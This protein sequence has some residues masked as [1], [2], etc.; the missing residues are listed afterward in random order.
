MKLKSIAFG[1]AVFAAT[2]LAHAGTFGVSLNQ[3]APGFW[4]AGYDSDFIVGPLLGGAPFV[5]GTDTVVFQDLLNP[6]AAGLYEVELTFHELA[7][8]SA[9]FGN[10]IT[11][12]SADVN[13]VPVTFFTKRTFTF[14]GT[15]AHPFVLTVNG[16]T[17]TADAGYHG[18]ITVTAVPE[19]ETYAMLL[20]GLGLMGAIAR[21]RGA[22]KSANEA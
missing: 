18:T 9:P 15:A 3:T 4:S 11:V 21:R 8:T 14:D 6:M 13:G 7:K 20:A 5:P 1:A 12:T 22:N 17:N 10:P 19:P 16:F 2:A